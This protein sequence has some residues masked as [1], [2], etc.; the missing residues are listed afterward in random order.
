MRGHLSRVIDDLLDATEIEEIEAARA[1]VR[2]KRA[3]F[4][5]G[6]RLR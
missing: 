2:A 5:A 4:T 6:R 1:D 3:R